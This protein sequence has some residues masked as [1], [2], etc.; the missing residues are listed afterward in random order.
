MN[1]DDMLCELNPE[2]REAVKTINGPLLVLAGAGTGKTRVI[3]YRIAYMVQS[4]IA[5][6]SIL[7]LTF[8]NKAARE[9]RARL[10]QLVGQEQARKVYL[11][12]F[13][14]FCVRL[15]RR[16]IK[17]LHYLPS[18]TIADE[19]DQTGL[20]KQAAAEV[21]YTSKQISVNEISNYISA[22]KNRLQFPRDAKRIA[23]NA[24]LEILAH[25]Y[26]QYQELLEMQNMLD[27][28]D[29]LLLTYDLF[30]RFPESLERCRDR[31][32][33]LL[34]DEYQ[35]TN[36]AQFT[37]IQML[38]GK[39]GNLCVVG[40]DDQ[41]IYGW[42][43]AKIDNIINFASHFNKVKKVKL[44]QNYRS[45]NKILHVAN[46]V[47]NANQNRH[48]KNLW[49]ALGDGENIMIL[50]SENAEKE[51]DFIAAYIAQ[52]VG[53]NQ[54]LRYDDFAV[55]YRS[56]YLSRQLELSLRKQNIPYR[57]VG[58]Q[59]FFK[60]KEIKDAVAYLRLLVNPT[61][62]QDFLRI[63][64]VPPRGLGNKAINMLKVANASS[65]IPMI[66]LLGKQEFL[67]QLPKKAAT[68]AERLHQLFYHFQKIF[69]S[70]GM[71]AKKTAD[72]L[73]AVGY[74]SGLQ[75]IYRDISDATK[76]R[77]N[78]DEFINAITQF[79]NRATQPQMLSNYLDNY[80]LMEENDRVEEKNNDSS[81]VT[82]TTIHAA[83]GLEFPRVFVMALEKNIFPHE[84]ALRENGLEEE[85]RLFYVAL[86]RARERLML[87]YCARRMHQGQNKNQLPS[88][89][90][91]TLPGEHIDFYQPEDLLKSVSTNELSAQIQ[92]ILV[93]IRS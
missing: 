39:S 27:F 58:G 18:F 64:G 15:L 31:Y 92:E 71:L 3:T 63:L 44:E 56:N 36:D 17:Q 87:S 43:G 90:L 78:V 16:E 52:E 12:T 55:L 48:A 86:T 5:P 60:R 26:G 75:K 35:D 30:T 1:M 61:N 66:E 68:E 13:H 22:R 88:D 29:M 21:G 76:R 38:A 4:G 9:M 20:I 70:P 80:A 82:L 42:R 83:K 10:T 57:L 91:S 28:D 89:F 40:D 69:S 62:N 84:R 85:R 19:S 8:T 2:Q 41:S 45:T 50:R 14:A 77:E 54:Q 47:I 6:E 79:E 7:G 46:M 53:T 37:L 11:G 23:D 67:K 49:S 73:D 34:V 93:S 74:R 59:E 65:H 25:I 72:F 32:H 24:K 81:A 33:Y 51:T